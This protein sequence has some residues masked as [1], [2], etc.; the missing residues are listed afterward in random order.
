[1]EGV[2]PVRTFFGLESRRFIQIGRPRPH[3]LM[4]LKSDFSKFIVCPHEQKKRGI[5][6]VRT[7]CVGR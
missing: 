4:Q 2:W 5:E 1:M 3:F 6:P 7:F